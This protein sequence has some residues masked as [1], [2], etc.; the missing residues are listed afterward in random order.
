[1][2]YNLEICKVVSRNIREKRNALGYSQEKLAEVSGIAPLTVWKIENQDMWPGPETVTALAKALKLRPYE[3]FLDEYEDSILPIQNVEK[4]K[5]QIL[6]A[7]EETLNQALPKTDNP[8]E[9]NYTISRFS[10]Q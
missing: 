7:V 5:I 2:K 6:N 10:R 9:Q 3:F 4:T 8:K 1:M